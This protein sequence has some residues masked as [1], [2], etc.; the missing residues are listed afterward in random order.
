MGKKKKRMDSEPFESICREKFQNQNGEIQSEVFAR[1]YESQLQSAAFTDLNNRQ[2][3]LYICCKAQYMGKR[4]PQEDYKE[5]SLFQDNKC[6]YLSKKDL[7]EN[8][9]LYT[10][11]MD[12]EIY[13]NAK[14]NIPGDFKVLEEHGLIDIIVNGRYKQKNIYRLSDRWHNWPNPP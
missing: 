14:Q 13:G 12:K 1:I 6:F 11:S 2:K 9:K 3:M 7:V 5:L 8:Y 10:S 4:K